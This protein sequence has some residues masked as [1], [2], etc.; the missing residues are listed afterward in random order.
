MKKVLNGLCIILLVALVLVLSLS[1]ILTPDKVLSEKENRALTRLPGFSAEKLFSGEYTSQFG[2]YIAD[3]FVMRDGFVKAKAYFELLQN[4]TENNGVIYT[5]EALIVRPSNDISRLADNLDCID[6]FAKN[7]NLSVTVAALPRL[8]DAFEEFLPKSYPKKQNLIVWQQL[9][10][11]TDNRNFAFADLYEL[12]CDSNEYYKTDHHYTTHGAFLTYKALGEYLG[13]VSKDK[14]CFDIELVSEDFEGTSMRTSGFYDFAKDS[15]YLYR[16]NDDD[17]YTVVADGDEI[18]LY[19][20]SKLETT[21]KYAVFLGGNHSRVDI[22]KNNENR[23]KLIIIRDSY[24]DSLVPFLAIH[25]DITLIDLRYYT[26]SVAKLAQ[27]NNVN[28]VLV[29]ESVEEIATAKNLSYLRM[30]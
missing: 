6:E 23:E 14:S 21:D 25:F 17:N 7:N 30:K 5:K 8:A 9:Y 28:K 3:Q 18:Q 4:K 13:Y 20:F 1:G 2:P 29:L 22:T 15:M 11:E 26:D 10:K 12:L 16:Y 24:A 19:D 27:E